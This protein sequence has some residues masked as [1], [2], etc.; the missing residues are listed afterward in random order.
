[1]ARLIKATVRHDCREEIARD[2]PDLV[3][4][5][6]TVVECS[7]GNQFRWSDDQRDGPYWEQI[8]TK[9]EPEGAAS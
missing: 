6:G 7:C 2:M 5:Y 4:Y 3:P 1:M 9:P 8:R